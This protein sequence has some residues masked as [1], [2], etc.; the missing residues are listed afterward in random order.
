MTTAWR[1]C[2]WASIGMVAITAACAT[3]T[4]FADPGVIEAREVVLPF[5]ASFAAINEQGT[6]LL[7][8]GTADATPRD[9]R[10]ETDWRELA[11]LDLET[12]KM[13]FRTTLDF[14]AGEAVLDGDRVFVADREADAIHVVPIDGEVRTIF[15][16][17]R[18]SKLRVV[19]GRLFTVTQFGRAV[20]DANTFERLEEFDR[21]GGNAH[22]YSSGMPVDVEGYWR[23]DGVI[24][25]HDL[26]AITMLEPDAIEVIELPSSGLFERRPDDRHGF[27][28]DM[29]TREQPRQRWGAAIVNGQLTRTSGQVAFHDPRAFSG[30]LLARHPAAVFVTMSGSRSRQ[31]ATTLGLQIVDVASGKAR[32]VEIANPAPQ[33]RREG[34]RSALDDFMP[35]DSPEIFETASG[36]VHVRGTRAALLTDAQLG[37]EDAPAPLHFVPVQEMLVAKGDKPVELSYEIRGGTL[38]IRYSL[39]S[40]AEFLHIDPE[41]GQV[42]VELAKLPAALGTL[43]EPLAAMAAQF[44][45]NAFGGSGQM[46]KAPDWRELVREPISQIAHKTGVRIDGFPLAVRIQVRARDANQQEAVLSHLL[47]VD[48]PASEYDA[49]VARL[50]RS[51]EAQRPSPAPADKPA[52]KADL[53]DEN[54]RLKDEIERLKGQ[55]ELLKQM[56]EEKGK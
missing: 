35:G 27:A 13:A 16:Q 44:P 55:V 5:T 24:H 26:S 39:V 43:L 54:R 18:V 12:A 19:A 49:L 29:F 9:A 30:M 1:G 40:K 17:G 52:D 23:I 25:T 51:A 45:A 31:S 47:V 22:G 11:I 46:P 42:R 8:L 56:L 4:V 7:I 36:I 33:E 32:R 10:I 6:G 48:I 28:V 34:R 2:G 21:A 14:V 53:A 50:E 41:T 20:F 37:L 3:P 15:T 38:P